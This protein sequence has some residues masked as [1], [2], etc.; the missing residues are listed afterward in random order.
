ME[1][2]LLNFGRVAGFAGAAVFAVAIVA[3]LLGIYWLGGSQVGTLLQA[4]IAAMVFG[5]FSLLTALVG[6][7]DSKGP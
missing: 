6:R 4:A 1:N 2:L 5:C 3:R 7:A